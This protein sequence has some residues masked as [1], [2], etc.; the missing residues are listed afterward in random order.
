MS[1]KIC[2]G[3]PMFVPLGEVA[4]PSTSNFPSW[5]MLVILLVCSVSV[6]VGVELQTKALSVHIAWSLGLYPYDIIPPCEYYT[7][8]TTVT[9]HC[10][11]AAVKTTYNDDD[12]DVIFTSCALS[13]QG[14]GRCLL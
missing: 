5:H 13:D 12:V 4:F 7:V 11:T 14:L 10:A 3:C 8:M 1:P 9:G 6:C 2:H